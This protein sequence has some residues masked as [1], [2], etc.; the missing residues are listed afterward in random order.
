MFKGAL[1]SRKPPRNEL[2]PLG[3]NLRENWARTV[4]DDED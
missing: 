2:K 4:V 1:M 3:R